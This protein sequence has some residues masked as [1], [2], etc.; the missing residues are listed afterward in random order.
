[1]ATETAN[2]HNSDAESS[3]EGWNRLQPFM[4][5]GVEI[6]PRPYAFTDHSAATTVFTSGNGTEV[7]HADKYCHRLHADE[8]TTDRDGNE[9]RYIRAH[10]LEKVMTSWL[11]PVKPCDYCTQDI[12]TTAEIAT[13]I[14]GVPEACLKYFEPGDERVTTRVHT[15]PESGETTV[16][17][18]STEVY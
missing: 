9:L 14:D 4:R 17:E 6:R 7:F 1:M 16:Q 13:E 8:P 15:D 5:D 12:E 18:S 3:D 10:T 2:E 11:D